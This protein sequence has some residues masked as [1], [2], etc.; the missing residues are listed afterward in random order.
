M[1]GFSVFL[2]TPM[3]DEKVAYIEKMTEQGFNGIFT[4]LHIPEDDPQHLLERLQ[5]LGALAQ[6]SKLN[7][8]VD[9]SN[10]ISEQLQLTEWND[11]LILKNMGVTGL[12]MDYGLSEDLMATLSQHFLIGL[13]ASTLNHDVLTKLTQAKMNF[14]NV[15]YWHNY[16]PRPETGLSK[17][18]FIAK[19]RWLKEFGGKVIAF[20]PGDG[21]LRGPL[22]RG[23]PTLEKHRGTH[24]LANSLELIKEC[25][26]D[27]VYV[28]DE[29]LSTDTAKQF[30]LY[31]HDNKIGLRVNLVSQEYKELVIGT[32]SNRLDEARDVIRSQ[33][34]RFKTL[35]RIKQ[36]NTIARNKGAVT[37]D[38]Y[39]YGR[40]SGELQVVK[41]P[42]TASSKVN[43]MGH[44]FNNDVALIDWITSGVTYE[45]IEGEI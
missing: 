36:I 34:A 45:L 26:V 19:N 17:Q 30:F 38:N 23:L 14:D 29:E 2:G 5:T 21:V 39:L 10:D 37:L 25:Y 31:T 43:V 11:Y 12:R 28:G 22:Y 3:T 4:S 42:L 1:F 15:E 41:T 9:I 44:V 6:K 32:H 40:Y 16:Y 33:E 27:Q 35:P 13:N 24:P 8:M 7:L 20:T 18:A